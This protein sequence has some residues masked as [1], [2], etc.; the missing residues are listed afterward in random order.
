MQPQQPQKYNALVLDFD[1]A[2]FPKRFFIT[3]SGA[4]PVLTRIVNVLCREYNFRIV[5]SAMMQEQGIE[6]CKKEL[7][8]AGIDYSFMMPINW[9]T[10]SVGFH[11]GERHQQIERWYKQHKND[12]QDILIFDDMFCPFQSP[13][14]EFWRRCDED[15]GLSFS[16]IQSLYSKY[17]KL[18]HH[19]DIK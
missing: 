15:T 7:S 6:A 14:N 9:A 2:L 12:I 5:I 11:G 8:R 18:L 16:E 13:I 17:P 3:N 19:K 10:L 1:G 4:D